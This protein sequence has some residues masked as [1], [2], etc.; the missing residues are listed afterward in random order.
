MPVSGSHTDIAHERVAV[1]AA[2]QR[3]HPGLRAVAPA[4]TQCWTASFIATSTATDPE[5]QKNTRCSGAGR[6]LDQPLGQR[7]GRSV[8][9]PA[10]HHVRHRAELVPHGVVEH[11]V[12]V[13]VHG[14]PPRGH[15]VDELATVGQPQPYA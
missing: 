5:S 9:E 11:L 2:A 12:P 14:R 10:Q 6:E 7:H 13:A 15:P 8:G 3:E 1:V 4:P